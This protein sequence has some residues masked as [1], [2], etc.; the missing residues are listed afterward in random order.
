MKLK[1]IFT[2]LAIIFIIVLC[3]SFSLAAKPAPQPPAGV[4][5]VSCDPQWVQL[6]KN[7]NLWFE[8][9]GNIYLYVNSPNPS[10]W[11]YYIV[12]GW[13]SL[14]FNSFGFSVGRGY[15]IDSIG[16]FSYEVW[17]SGPSGRWDFF[18]QVLSVSANTV[19]SF[20]SV[21]YPSPIKYLAQWIEPKPVACPEGLTN[22]VDW[23]NY[24]SDEDG[25]VYQDTNWIRVE[26]QL[27]SYITN[28]D[29]SSYAGQMLYFSDSSSLVKVRSPS[30]GGQEFN[31]P[32]K[33]AY[34]LVGLFKP[35]TPGCADADGDGYGAKNTDLSTCTKSTTIADCNDDDSGFYPGSPPRIKDI[36]ADPEV[37]YNPTYVTDTKTNRK[38]DPTYEKITPIDNII[39]K[40]RINRCSNGN[41]APAVLDFGASIHTDRFGTDFEVVSGGANVLNLVP[42]GD[43]GNNAVYQW[44]INGWPNGITSDANINYILD[45]I[46]SNTAINLVL[47]KGSETKK[48]PIPMSGCAHLW[49]SYNLHKVVTMRGDSSAYTISQLVG[50]AEDNRK[51]GFQAIQPFSLH[52]NLFTYY[53][54]LH[55]YSDSSLTSKAESKNN[56]AF[57]NNL[58]QLSACKSA[59]IYNFYNQIIETSIAKPNGP[60]ALML[61]KHDA[62]TTIHEVGHS[63]CGLNDEYYKKGSFTDDKSYSTYNCAIDPGASFKDKVSGILYGDVIYKGCSHEKLGPNILGGYSPIY[64]PSINSIMR[65]VMPLWGPGFEGIYGGIKQFN[66]ISCGYCLQKITTQGT[67]EQNWLSCMQMSDTIKPG[68]KCLVDGDCSTD[69]SLGCRKCDKSTNTCSNSP[70]L[71]FPGVAGLYCSLLQNSKMV[72]GTCSTG[73]CTIDP[74]I[75]CLRNFDCQN[76]YDNMSKS[77]LPSIKRC[78]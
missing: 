44:A 19:N 57:I 8:C 68:N 28:P 41:A 25:N 24:F 74:S 29:P 1:I 76:N 37:T 46:T 33:I 16:S 13:N 6:G 23:E 78:I 47:S 73:L 55:K 69:N 14:R 36:S 72:W 31:A 40:V 63:F 15:S 26:Q 75:E 54:D 53:V 38:F 21:A 56:L 66:V 48:T 61:T 52:K 10:P 17:S 50:K 20:G 11:I 32:G 67:L 77:C 12:P 5:V 4:K 35:V 22:C 34:S 62:S 2:F 49:G 60:G 71:S 30:I 18:Q 42:N 43:G 64:R 51:N 58:P 65:D 70:G 9:A 3:T 45:S 39:A 27:P 59:E 7:A